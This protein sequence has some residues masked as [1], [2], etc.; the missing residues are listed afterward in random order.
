[1]MRAKKKRREEGRVAVDSI[2]EEE[3]EHNSCDNF[4]LARHFPF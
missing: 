2:G 1:M 3:G 4:P